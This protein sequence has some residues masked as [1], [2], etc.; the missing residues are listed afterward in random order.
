MYIYPQPGDVLFIPN[1]WA[2]ATL[3]LEEYTLAVAREFCTCRGGNCGTGLLHAVVYI[4]IYAIP[5]VY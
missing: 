5:A 1:R 4:R 2:H 3:N